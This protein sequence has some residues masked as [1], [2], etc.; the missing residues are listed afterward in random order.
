MMLHA[1]KLTSKC[2]VQQCSI[3]YLCMGN[4]RGQKTIIHQLQVWN[5]DQIKPNNYVPSFR[6]RAFLIIAG[7]VLVHKL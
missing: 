3:E 7:N 2:L 4:P 5:V 1:K 6:H